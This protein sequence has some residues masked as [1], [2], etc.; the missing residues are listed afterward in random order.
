MT[1]G[2]WDKLGAPMPAAVAL[3][4]VDPKLRRAVG[5]AWVLFAVV[6]ALVVVVGGA[7][8]LWSLRGGLALTEGL[9][10][11]P[12]ILYVRRKGLPIADSLRWR[13]V[14]IGMAARAVVLGVTGW[15]MAVLVVLGSNALLKPFIGAPPDFSALMSPMIAT[16]VWQLPPILLV[17]A[18]LPGICEETLFRGAMQGTVER[19]GPWKAVVLIAALFAAFHMNP[20]NL[21]PA[22]VLGLVFGTL[23]VRTSSIVPSMIA[24][25][26]NNATSFVCAF[27]FAGKS[28]VP[29][30]WLIVPLL[31]TFVAAFSE[32]MWHSRG[33][34]RRPSPLSLAPAGVSWAIRVIV[35]AAAL[36]LACL[37][38][39][40]IAAARV[41]LTTAIVPADDPASSLRQGDTVLLLRNRWAGPI[42]TRGDLVVYERCGRT[43][44]RK[45]ARMDETSVWVAR[46]APDGAETEVAV[47][48]G[49]LLGRVLTTIP[50]A[51]TRPGAAGG[52]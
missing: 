38:V 42:L 2:S 1:A 5:D 7:A 25:A 49:D 45:V 43:I 8:Q 37:I 30:M 27:L 16:S 13:P 6:L 26:C 14:S 20:W 15:G 51:L 17:G 28:S 9:I 3:P 12:A 4:G 21:V 11:L 24:H 44:I 50:Q 36:G 23:T 35:V 46:R 18:V 32:V 33:V 41:G 22:F 52:T 47:P 31:I 48:R 34:E 40:S 10:L 19:R 39:V 29:P